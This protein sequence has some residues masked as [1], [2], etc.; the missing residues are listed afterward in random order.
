MKRT[1]VDLA[2]TLL[3]D[4]HFAFDLIALVLLPH[5]VVINILALASDL[6]QVLH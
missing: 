2:Q 1:T 4:V 3:E 5:Y 6:L